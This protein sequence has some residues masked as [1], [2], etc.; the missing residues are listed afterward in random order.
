MEFGQALILVVVGDVGANQEPAIVVSGL[1]PDHF[2]NIRV[3]AVGSNNFQAGSRVIRLRTFGSD[4]R[5]QLGTARLPSSFV[6]EEQKQQHQGDHGEDGRSAFPALE[7]AGPDGP[8][9]QGFNVP[10]GPGSRRNTVTRRHSPSTASME[11]P[12]IREESTGLETLEELTQTFAAV[13]KEHEEV[14]ATIA[15]EEIENKKQLDELEAEKAE[16]RKELKQKEEQTKKLTREVHSTDKAMRVAQANK[17]KKERELEQKIKEREKYGDKIADW[18]K[19]MAEMRQEMESFEVQRKELAQE[20]DAK[21]DELRHA[22]PE[23]QQECARLEHELKC[24]RE[25]VRKLED[26]RKKLPGGDDDEEWRDNV[27]AFKQECQRRYRMLHEMVIEENRMARRLDEQLTV[28]QMQLSAIPVD[29]GRAQGST[30]APGMALYSQPNSSGIEFDS[31]MVTQLKRR[32]RNSNSL[33]TP[34]ISSPLPAYSAIDPALSAAISQTGFHSTRINPPPGLSGLPGFAQGPFMMQDMPSRLDEDGIRASSAP[35]S[36]SAAAL[37]PANILDDMDDDDDLSPASG[38]DP[39]DPFGIQGNMTSV[40]DEQPPQSPASSERPMSVLSSPQGSSRNVPSRPSSAQNGG[41]E[42]GKQ[43]GSPNNQESPAHKGFG[44]FFNFQRSRHAN[45]GAE[46]GAGPALGSLKHGQSQSFP[47]QGDDID[48][49]NKSRRISLSGGWNMFGRNSAGPDIV[50]GH[51]AESRGFSARALNPFHRSVNN[52]FADRDPSSPR[53]MSV[54]SSELPRPSTDSGSIWGPSVMDGVNLS[55]A[56]RVWAADGAWTSS[57]APSRRPSL[58]GSPSALKTTLASAEDEILDE[59]LPHNP[60]VGIIGRPKA[61]GSKSFPRMNPTVPAFMPSLFQRKT[62]K[63]KDGSK[64]KEKGKGKEKTK[65]KKDK[66]KGVETP[67]APPSESES[68][69]DSRISRD[70]FSVHTQVSVSESHE[71]LMLDQPLSNTPSEPVSATLSSSL[72]DE[73]V[74]RKLFRKGSS[75]KFG[76]PGRLGVKDGSSLFKKGPSSNAGT[77]DTHAGRSSMG[78]S[79]EITMFDDSN[80]LLLG[81]SY[82]SIT[83][84][85]SL[86]PTLTNKTSRESKSGTRWLSFSKIGRSKEKESLDLEREKVAES[87]TTEDT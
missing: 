71:S 76:L 6:A 2:Y 43:L 49:T 29:G 19:K 58:H 84:S 57:R 10:G 31:A 75:S 78:D 53:P 72:K 22:L 50:E 48:G 65:D 82:E 55:K 79:E 64:E 32:S 61:S 77:S 67:V 33:S 4:G 47:R 81:R 40:N 74:V 8:T 28:L 73:N 5:P 14:L 23:L 24:K 3:I 59:E 11:P 86:G 56:N 83:S 87:E 52:P 46:D 17:T 18:E 69:S 34:S 80:S 62:D 42:F 30:Q 35:L 51:V 44:S 41:T 15:K 63:D 70:T 20:R 13:R 45:K 68:P 54:A 38:F 16:K 85:P 7:T 66:S 39:T 27:A 60:A 36:P 21:V 25:D 26:E 1:K 12:P 37:L 9:L